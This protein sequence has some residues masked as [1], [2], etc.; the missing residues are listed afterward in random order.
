LLDDRKI[1]H[2]HEQLPV[3]ELQDECC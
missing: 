1:K 3:K 2:F